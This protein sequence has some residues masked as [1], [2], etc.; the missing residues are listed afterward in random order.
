MRGGERAH[1]EEAASKEER[2]TGPA[3]EVPWGSRRR[4]VEFCAT[5]FVSHRCEL[6]RC[7]N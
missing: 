7:G 4:A 2:E 6:T 5:S 1:F 3:A